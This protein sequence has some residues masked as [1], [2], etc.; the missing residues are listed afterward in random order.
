MKQNY[1]KWVICG[2]LLKDIPKSQLIDDGSVLLATANRYGHGPNRGK[3][4]MP[5]TGQ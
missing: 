4:Q 1:A 5:L 2:V 3:N